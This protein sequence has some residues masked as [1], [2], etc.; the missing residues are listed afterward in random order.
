MTRDEALRILRADPATLR[1]LGVETLSLFGSVARDEAGPASDVD[2]L[3]EF[4]GPATFNGYMEL[5]EYLETLLGA[6]VDLVTTGG[7]RQGVRPYIEREM[8]RVA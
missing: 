8:I 7:L 6:S 3:V 5:L 1:E 2:L 4:D